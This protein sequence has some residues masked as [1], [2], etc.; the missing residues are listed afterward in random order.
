M[1]KEYEKFEWNDSIKLKDVLNKVSDYDK[2][3][4]LG[5]ILYHGPRND[6]PS[7]YNPKEIV[8]I[9]NKMKEKII[10]VRGNCDAK[11]DLMVLDFNIED[12]KWIN[13][14]GQTFFLSHGD[15]YSSENPIKYDSK[16]FMLY[17]HYHK[18][19]VVNIDNVT[20]INLGSLSIPKDKHYSYAIVDRNG[21]ASYDL[22]SNEI[23]LKVDFA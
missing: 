17:G 12:N 8:E 23:I 15:D 5:D 4:I 6:L 13:L 1:E 22:E 21:Y 16:C 10:A 19:E 2:L 9:L 18:N 3:I 20:C 14:N 7:G 11:V